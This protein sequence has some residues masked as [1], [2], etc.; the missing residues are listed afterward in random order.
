[1]G[2]GG[3]AKTPIGLKIARGTVRPSDRKRTEP[4]AGGA[5]SCPSWLSAHAKVVWKRLAPILTDMK[6]ASRADSESLAMFCDAVSDFREAIIA[7]AKE[8]KVVKSATG[9]PMPH[10]YVAIKNKAAANIAKF[11]DRFGLSPAA[12]AS[13]SMETPKVPDELEKLQRDREDRGG[14]K[15][16]RA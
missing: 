14:R 1:M 10:P 11:G 12:R 3:R 5:P 9:H 2:R 4:S 15:R 7:L 8:G 16:K 6:I 13:L